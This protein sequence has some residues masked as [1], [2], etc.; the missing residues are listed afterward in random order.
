MNQAQKRKAL[1]ASLI[2]NSIEWY[3]YLLYGTASALVFNHLFFPTGD[4]A[5]STMLAFLTFALPF[6]IRP[7]GGILFSHIGDKIG[8]KKT[9]IVTLMLMGVS[10]VIIGLLPGYDQ[11]GIWAPVLLITLRIVQGIGIGGEWGGALLLAVENSDKEK[12]GLY[13]SIPQMGV[14]IGMLLGTVAMA[15]ATYFTTSEQFMSW[16]WR[17]PFLFSAILVMVGLWMRKDIDESPVFKEMK[18]KGE[19]ANIPIVDTFKYHWKEVLLATGL[20]V[21][22]TAPFYLLSSFVIT[23]ATTYAGVDKTSALNAVSLG[24]LTT[25][26]FIPLCG[27]WADKFGRKPMYIT[28]TV[29]MM[30]FTFPYFWML[31]QGTALMVIL[32]TV[33]GLGIIWSPI[34]AVLGTLSSEIFSTKV[35]Y[36]GVT[37]GYQL[38]AAIAGGTAPFVAMALLAK[39]D[40]SWIPVAI[41]FSFT[42]LISLITILLIKETKGKDL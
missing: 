25:L 5:I 1:W 32:A 33:I 17:I 6:F 22:E 40:N 10:T 3:D 42:A 11:I 7:L 19:T 26:F 4:L 30:L 13:G 39:F 34:T 28:G 36:T 16:G 21:V 15:C 9:L 24:A 8:R 31:N 37:V 14:S 35:R 20:K 23:Y 29:A 18:E 12:R 2:G 38:G 41:Y 27:K